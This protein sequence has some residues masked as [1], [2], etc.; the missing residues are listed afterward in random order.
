M[1]EGVE[2]PY[3]SHPYLLYKTKECVKDETFCE[4][5]Y[6]F[7][8]VCY[9]KCPSKT[10]NS[11]DENNK[12]CKC[13]SDAGYWAKG[14]DKYGRDFLECGLPNCD[15]F[16]EKNK[17][18]NDTKECVSNCEEISKYLYLGICYS[19]CPPLTTQVINENNCKLRT[20]FD[21]PDLQVLLKN[22]EEKILEINEHIPSGGLVVNNE[23]NEA[24]LQVY[25][26][27]KNEQKNKEALLRS[28]LAYIDISECIEK[29]YK[30]NKMS[31][32]EKVIVVKLDLKSNNKKLIVSPVEY[33]FRNSKTGALLDASVCGRNEIVISY[34]ITYLL[35][36]KRKLRLLDDEEL[37]EIGEK[38]KRGK[39]LHEKDN[40]IDSFNYNSTIY[41][42]ICYP[43]E[44][45]GKDLNLENRISYFYPNYSFCESSCIYDYTDFEGE[46]IYCNCSIKLKLDIDRPQGAKLSEYNKE[47]TDDNQMGP[48]NLP[49]L[50]CISKVKIGGN[51]A[52]YV[53]LI[54]LLVQI[55]LLFYVIFKGI[56]SVIGNINKKMFKK[57]EIN[58]SNV[59]EDF[60]MTVKNKEDI[61]GKTS[62]R[63]LNNPPKK[64]N[65]MEEK[66][67]G[68]DKN[69]N[70]KKKVRKIIEEKNKFDVFSESN[71]SE[72][73][74][75]YLKKNEIDIEKGFF[76][77]MQKEQKYLR[78]NFSVSMTKDKYDFVVVVLTSIF[79]KIYLSKVLLF[80]NKYQITSLMFSLYLLCHLLLL[81]FCA[82][83]FDI[84][85]I[86]KIF[87]DENYPSLGY[88]ILYGFLG[89]LIVWVIFKLFYCLIDNS[90]SIRKLFKKNNNT[91]NNEKKMVRLNKLISGIKRGAIIY[92]VIQFILI[93][94]CS[95]YLIA[96]CGIYTGT[97]TKLFLSY[98]FAIVTI[99]IIKIVYGLIL[100]ILR[101]ISLFAEKNTLYNVVLI[102]NKYIS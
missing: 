45:D 36:N 79:D 86:G 21:D 62:E 64:M 90:N 63:K 94:L 77:S 28:N 51:P 78:E 72:E 49:I 37:I 35:R 57:E 70:G 6:I 66:N 48:T 18:D 52:F 11:S 71:K 5:K 67:K 85:T 80:S 20:E 68:K 98:A 83:F 69:P 44:V 31:G 75:N 60:K 25:R 46:R 87:E 74:Y 32:D 38:F 16:P 92:L 55:C 84:K 2:C 102:F 12:N 24:T 26:L 82:L 95:F 15:K 22:V 61:I 42:N 96:F 8:F 10:T 13:D 73:Y 3:T 34:P 99:A 59:E 9:D 100:G 33:E 54:F 88:Y 7:N 97:K 4:G 47:E 50:R 41:S 39:S 101:K 27:E 23:E 93:F 81:T 1:G 65:Y 40:S 14:K 76:T 53:C 43:I 91:F 89:N 58:D 17:Y 30:N 56:S 29:I 19:S